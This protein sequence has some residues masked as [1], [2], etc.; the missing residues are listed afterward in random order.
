MLQRQ[1]ELEGIA[2][3]TEG[4]QVDDQV[5]TNVEPAKCCLGRLAGYELRTPDSL[6]QQPQDDRQA[7]RALQDLL[8]TKPIKRSPTG[9]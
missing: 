9:S 7:S 4:Q 5:V 3:P 1:A 8:P 6:Q 2:A